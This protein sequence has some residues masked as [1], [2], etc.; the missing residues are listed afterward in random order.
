MKG[1]HTELKLAN[2][3]EVKLTPSEVTKDKLSELSDTEKGNG[4]DAG[5]NGPFSLYR[6]S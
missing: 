6:S 2:E 3:T 4:L 5:W 1:E